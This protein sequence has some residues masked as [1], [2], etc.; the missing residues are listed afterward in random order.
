M[1]AFEGWAACGGFWYST[2]QRNATSGGRQD[3]AVQALAGADG[4]ASGPQAWQATATARSAAMPLKRLDRRIQGP[5]VWGRSAGLVRGGQW[6]INSKHAGVRGGRP[7]RLR[8]ERAGPL[9][10]NT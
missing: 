6:G 8:G 5:L 7:R 2:P 1:G 9:N 10:D 3:S 4:L